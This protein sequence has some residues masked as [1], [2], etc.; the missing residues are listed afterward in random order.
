MATDLILEIVGEMDNALDAMREAGLHD[1][2]AYIIL[3]RRARRME[4]EAMRHPY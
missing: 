3:W 4:E 1:T 2:L